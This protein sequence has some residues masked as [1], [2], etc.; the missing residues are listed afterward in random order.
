MEARAGNKCTG[1]GRVSEK[2]T[3][4]TGVE[5]TGRNAHDTDRVAEDPFGADGGFGRGALS[6]AARERQGGN[7]PRDGYY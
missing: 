1:E 2:S 3:G 7:T 4:R 5:Y 6:A